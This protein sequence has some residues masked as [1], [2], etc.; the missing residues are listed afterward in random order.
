MAD[1]QEILRDVTIEVEPNLPFPQADKFER[2]INL[3]ELLNEKIL[4]KDEVTAKY[5]FDARQT[6]YYTSAARYLGLIDD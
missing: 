5:D 4:N 2:V 1:I 3:C 6:D